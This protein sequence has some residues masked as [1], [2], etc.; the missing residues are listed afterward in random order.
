MSSLTIALSM[1]IQNVEIIVATGITQDVGR[2]FEH[3][4]GEPITQ[5]RHGIKHPCHLTLALKPPSVAIAAE[6]S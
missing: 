3:T 5:I 6:K 4:G 1:G 2:Y